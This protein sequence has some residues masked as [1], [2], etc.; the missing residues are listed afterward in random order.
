MGIIIV[1]TTVIV[2]LGIYAILLKKYFFGSN[3]FLDQ[4]GKD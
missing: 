4:D 1:L 2:G 3:L